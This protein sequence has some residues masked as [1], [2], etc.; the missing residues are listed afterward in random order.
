M[1]LV[2]NTRPDI[3]ETVRYL[4]RMVKNPT[5][6]T[7]ARVKRVLRYLRGSADL[8]NFFPR[9]SA[10]QWF[11]SYCDA[12]GPNDADRKSVSGFVALVLGAPVSWF[13]RTQKV[14]SLDMCGAEYISTTMGVREGLWVYRLFKVMMACMLPNVVL[15]KGFVMR[16]DNTAALMVASSRR[17][18]KGTKHL[19]VKFHYIREVVE[20]GQV[21]LEHVG[22]AK[23]LSDLLTKAMARVRFCRLR[24][25]LMVNTGLV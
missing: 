12:S 10:R 6:E 15:G 3:A 8:G 1:W 9:K 21:L 13:A 18:Y 5:K 2:V 24:D 20:L 25:A 14:V 4:S 17:V 11:E 7:T 19:E 16:T 23:N 22:S